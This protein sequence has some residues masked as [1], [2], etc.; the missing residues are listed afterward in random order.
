MAWQVEGMFNTK[1]ETHTHTK[2]LGAKV[3]RVVK[4]YHLPAHIA[5]HVAFISDIVRFPSLDRM[6]NRRKVRT[7]SMCICICM[8]F[9]CVPVHKGCVHIISRATAFRFVLSNSLVSWRFVKVFFFSLFQNIT[10]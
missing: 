1:F 8:C 4:P 3:H 10:T 2:V 6:A 7:A 9:V 5:Q